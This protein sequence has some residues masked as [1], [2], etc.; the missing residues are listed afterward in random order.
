MVE[1]LVCDRPEL[2]PLMQGVGRMA[3]NSEA[4]RV[5]VL[6]CGDAVGSVVSVDYGFIAQEWRLKVF[7]MSCLQ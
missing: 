1:K 6:R 2:T 5:I 3:E 4:A 7:A